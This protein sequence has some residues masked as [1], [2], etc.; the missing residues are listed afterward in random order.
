MIGALQ[1]TGHL[2]LNFE[3][4]SDISLRMGLMQR[5]HVDTYRHCVRVAWLSE[6]LAE[7]MRMDSASVSKLVRG[8][9]IHDLGKL[10]IPNEVL[11]NDRPLTNEQWDLIKQHPELGSEMLRDKSEICPEIIQ[12]VL[13][14]HERWDGTGYP[15]RLR[16]EK[17]PFLA[18]I[19]SVVDAFD[20]MLS[21]R[22][23][24]RRKTIEE[25]MAEL[26]RNAGTQFDPH[27]VERFI[28]LAKELGRIYLSDLQT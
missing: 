1:A 24:R 10:M 17:I 4:H 6:K 26:V 3:H 8:C 18:R 11:D 2:P 27:I 5:K 22:P 21:P 25:G 19:C 14:H 20:S 13:H 15:H 28:P 23:Y 16:G 7:A 9:F 12:L